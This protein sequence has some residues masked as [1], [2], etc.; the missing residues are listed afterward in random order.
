MHGQYDYSRWYKVWNLWAKSVYV[1][2]IACAHEYIYE[3]DL[4]SLRKRERER[5]AGREGGEWGLWYL[6]LLRRALHK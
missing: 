5:E 4:E 2:V 3:V 1:C 6:M